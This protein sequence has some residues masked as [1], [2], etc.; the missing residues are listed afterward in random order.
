M[1]TPKS[2]SLLA[3][4][5]AL[6][7]SSA[8]QAT[9]VWTDSSTVGGNA[10]TASAS[11]TI[12]GNTLTIVLKNTSPAAGL[13]APTN[14]LTG[15]SFLLTGLDPVLTPVSAISPNAIFSSGSCNANPCT[16]TNVN[17]GGEWG[18]QNNFSGKEGIGSAG[19]IT[20]GLSGNLGNFN[21]QNLQNP[22]SLDGIQFGIISATHGSLNGGLSGQA[23]I[24]D[25][26]ILTLT[27]VSGFTED[28][29]GSVSSYMVRPPMQR[30]PEPWFRRCRSLRR[31]RSSAR[32]CL[33]SARYGA[34]SA[35]DSLPPV[36]AA[37][38]SAAF[39]L[40]AESLAIA[41]DACTNHLPSAGSV[42]PA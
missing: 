41:G 14:T 35:A 15:L 18:Y 30:C 16:G 33:A 3:G 31:W 26:I 34:G 29:I 39:L 2:L 37:P 23:L 17:V 21:G 32:R 8:A 22:T 9:V 12:S 24:D 6:A 7:L 10:V 36:R 13:E 38:S 11:F 25:T 5:V 42:T 20:T 19:Y 4:A 28:Q 1:S 40:C 27:G